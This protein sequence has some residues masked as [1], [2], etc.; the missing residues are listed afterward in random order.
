MKEWNNLGHKIR[1]SKSI[2]IFKNNILRPKPNNV[3]YCHNPRG[4]RL[5]T[6]LRLDLSHLQEYKFKHSFQDLILLIYL[7]AS[8]VMILNHLLTTN[9]TDLPIQTKE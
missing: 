3:Y 6:G 2:S 1:K 5:M 7:D 9:L 8:A 4:V